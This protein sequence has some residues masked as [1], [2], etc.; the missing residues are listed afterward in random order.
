MRLFLGS[1]F[2]MALSLTME[3]VLPSGVAVTMDHHTC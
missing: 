1:K 2:G 3:N